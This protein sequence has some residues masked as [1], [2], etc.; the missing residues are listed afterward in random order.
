MSNEQ[1]YNFCLKS[2]IILILPQL[3]SFSFS[4]SLCVCVC[5]CVCAFAHAYIHI[6]TIFAFVAGLF[7]S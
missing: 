6:R 5:V 2:P 3:L 1:V 7:E 4:L